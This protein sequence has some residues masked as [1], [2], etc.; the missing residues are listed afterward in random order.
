MQDHPF[1]LLGFCLLLAHEMDAVRVGEWKMFPL[2][3]RLRDD[4]GYLV[5]TAL[6]VP[7]YL[8]L[9]WGIVGD[10]GTT[11]GLIVGLDTFFVVHVLLHLLFVGRPSNRFRSTFSWTLILSAGLFGVADVL[12][13]LV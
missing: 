6:H 8:V 2:L 1:F 3:S 10:G 11:L 12:M 7:L 4:A 13:L 9:I 5:F